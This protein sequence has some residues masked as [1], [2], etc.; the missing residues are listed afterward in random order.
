MSVLPKEKD[1]FNRQCMNNDEKK[2]ISGII[3]KIK[4][5][6]LKKNL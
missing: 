4:K 1:T 5:R 3:K 6:K 2:E